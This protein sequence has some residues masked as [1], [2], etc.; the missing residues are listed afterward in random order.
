MQSIEEEIEKLILYL[1][2]YRA[3]MRDPK[4]LPP[5]L[6][7]RDELESKI[8]EIFVTLMGY[9]ASLREREEEETGKI[10]ERMKYLLNERIGEKTM[11]ESSRL[12]KEEISHLRRV[13]RGLPKIN[14]G[15]REIKANLKMLEKTIK[16]LSRKPAIVNLEESKTMKEIFRLRQQL[17][18]L[19]KEATED[20]YITYPASGEKKTVEAGTIAFDFLTGEVTLHDGT[21][22]HTS[23]RLENTDFD[24]VKSV[25]VDINKD[26]TLTLDSGGK[27]P[28]GA[29]QLFSIDRQKFRIAYIECTETTKLTV[30]ASTN[31]EGAIRIDKP[32]T[33]DTD[34]RR[35]TTRIEYDGS[36]NPIYVG[37]AESGSGESELKWR[38]K[39]LTYTG[40]NVTQ[41]D[42]CEGSEGF[43]Y[44]WSER[45]SYSYS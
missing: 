11:E 9:G 16:N 7:S 42:W 40:S 12:I 8:K 29:N 22:E 30:W 27:Y 21:I 14:P 10:D 5:G 17:V 13:I 41:I 6:Q 33:I 23:N 19:G 20:L 18:N 31:E 44:K 2:S 32:D 28:V 34:E 37:E 1:R 43:K 4:M 3:V 39:K 25:S 36:N 45:T 15:E 35:Y 24:V 38:I 26:V